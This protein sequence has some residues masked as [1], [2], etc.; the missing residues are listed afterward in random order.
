M[1]LRRYVR[2]GLRRVRDLVLGRPDVPLMTRLLRTDQRASTFLA[3]IDYINYEGVPGDIVE[4]GVFTGLSLALLAQGSLFDPKGMTRRIIGFDSFDGLPP[5]SEAHA[6]W[7]EGACRIST[8]SHPFVEP[9]TR[10]TPEITERLF[11]ACGLPSP[12]LHVGLFEQTVPSVVPS[13]YPAIALAHLDCDLYESTRSALEA[14]A[15]ALQD[16]AMLLF[17][18]W[19]HYRGNPAKGEARAFAEF[20]DTHPE[21]RSVHYRSYATFC[22][23]FIVSRR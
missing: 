10:V 12:E 7:R 6:R 15:P 16:G 11:A 5:A 17:D 4:F 3:A 9:G 14:I 23:A 2:G 13:R 22:N 21:W 8:D 19:F 18:D 1:S 20:L